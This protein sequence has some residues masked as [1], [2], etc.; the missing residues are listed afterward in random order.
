MNEKHLLSISEPHDLFHE[1]R[2]LLGRVFAYG[3]QLLNRNVQRFRGGL[4]FEAHRLVN[5]STLGLRIIKKKYL[6]TEHLLSISEPHDLFHEVRP[7]LH[8]CR[9][10]PPY[11]STLPR[12]GRT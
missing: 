8:C 2:P 9:A 3:E 11:A 6:R 4:V 12:R 1:V 5:H 10:P 7:Q